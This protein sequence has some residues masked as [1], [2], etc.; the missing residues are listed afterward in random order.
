MSSWLIWRNSSNVM[1]YQLTL[2][3]L[4]PRYPSLNR[5]YIDLKLLLGRLSRVMSSLQPVAKIDR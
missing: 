1:S 4:L 5:S 2:A 3:L